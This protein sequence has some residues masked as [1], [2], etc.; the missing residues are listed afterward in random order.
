MLG[1]GFH[2]ELQPCMDSTVSFIGGEVPSGGTLVCERLVEVEG[3]RERYSE[4]WSWGITFGHP[5]LHLAGL[6]VL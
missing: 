1:A 2:V 4:G 3:L 6:G 5:W